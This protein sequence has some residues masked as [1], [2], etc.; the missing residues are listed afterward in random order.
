MKKKFLLSC[1]F[2]IFLL[3]TPLMR[4]NTTKPSAKTTGQTASDTKAD[5]PASGTPD[6]D[7]KADTLTSEPPASNG[8]GS[9][10]PIASSIGTLTYYNQG[11]SRWGSALYGGNDPISI[12]GCGPTVLAM[13]VS[14][15]TEEVILPD[16]MARWAFENHYWSSGSGSAHNLI[17]DGAA[18][19]GLHSESFR[20]LTSDGVKS[21][22][23][24]GKILV[25][26]MGPGHFTSSGHFI[27]I[28]NYWSD[29]QVSVADPASVERTSEPWDIDLLLSE[30]SYSQ[31][32]GGPVWAI[33]PH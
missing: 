26:L 22:L 29:N 13:L 9:A 4:E 20:E 31:S 24:H 25:A 21:A 12:Y 7:A 2:I 16:A 10:A 23:K 32:Y 11:D 18:A 6:S 17:P 30:L 19:F 28:S 1:T 14:S 3:C 8:I 27:I 15:F 33:S 5:A